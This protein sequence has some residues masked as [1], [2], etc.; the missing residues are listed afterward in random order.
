M[1]GAEP[2]KLS[3][4]IDGVVKCIDNKVG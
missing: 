2:K 1:E 4:V 3:Y